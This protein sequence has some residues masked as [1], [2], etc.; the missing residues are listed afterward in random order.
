MYQRYFLAGFSYRLLAFESMGQ[1]N[2]RDR[3]EPSPQAIFF[4]QNLGGY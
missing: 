3:P 1:R 4:D 2:R